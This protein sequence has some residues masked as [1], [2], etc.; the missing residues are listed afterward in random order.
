MIGRK[1]LL[2]PRIGLAAVLL[3]GFASVAQA[4]VPTGG[5]WGA[6]QVNGTAGGTVTYSFMPTG[7]S[8]SGEHPGTFTTVNTALASFQT[9]VIAAFA[10]WEAVANIHF[11]NVADLGN[12]FNSGPGGQGTDGSGDIRIGLATFDGPGGVLAHAFFSQPGAPSFAGDIHFDVAET[13]KTGIGGPGF[14]IFQVAAHEIGHAIGL[15]HTG[16]A[17]SLMNPFYT[18]AFLGLQAD[19][20]A[21][22]QFRYGA[23]VVA[24]PEPET[25]A[26]LLAGLGLLGFVARRRRQRDARLTAS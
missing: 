26:M 15:G 12:A 4:F 8:T 11:V 19:D 16:V 18:E 1:Q 24:V 6:S 23:A 13:W 7:T 9:Q 5:K 14:N 21:G 10:A 17:N 3:C 25:Y 2:M 22:A 20:I